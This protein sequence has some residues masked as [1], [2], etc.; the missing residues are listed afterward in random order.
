MRTVY[1]VP[2]CHWDREWYQPQELFRWRLVRMI[3]ELLDHM[4][5]CPDFRCFNLDG[6][7]I[8]VADY[9]ALRPENEGRLR[10]LVASGR[11]TIGPWWVQPDEF[12]P[13]AE[14]HIRN[15]QRGVRYAERLS[16]CARVGHCADQFG[17][18]AQL[19]QIMRQFGLT[20]ACLWRGVPDSI[21][22]WSFW[23]ESP[24]GS[25]LPVLYLRNSYS[26]GWRL[27]EDVDG[28]LARAGREERDRRDN[29]PVLLMNGTDHSRMEKHV[30]AALAQA[31]GRG[32]DF[33]L[34]TL[35]EYEAAMVEAGFDATVHRGEL[36]SPDRSNILA[37]VL[38]ARLNLK[39][40]DFAVSSLL[41][42]CAEPLELLAFL[43]GGSDRR[44]ALRRAWDLLLENAPHDS[45]CGCS[46]DQVHREMLPRYDRA[47]Q[48]AGQVA[49]EAVAEMAPRF[50]LPPEG[51]LL[52]F[53]PIA[54]APVPVACHVPARWSATQVQLPSGDRVPCAL[55]PAAEDETL[56]DEDLSPAEILARVEF[57]REGL[58]DGRRVQAIR[59]QLR[60]RR[61][62]VD[63]VVGDG[64]ASF[65]DGPAREA[66]R[67]VVCDGLADAARLRVILEGTRT[68]RLSLPAADSVGLVLVRPDSGEVETVRSDIAADKDRIG[69][70]FFEV[71]FRR[72]RLQVHDWQNGI[73]VENANVFVDE[74]DRG[75]EYNADILPDAVLEP[76]SA[77]LL[78][79]SGDG[80]SATLRYLT[81]LDVPQ[82]LRRDRKARRRRRDLLPIVT[83]V[84]LW[85]GVPRVD[86]RVVVENT[87][88]DHRLR[89]LFPLPF[90]AASVW[91]ENQ[92]HVAERSI[93]PPPWNGVS[94][95]QPPVTFPQKTFAACEAEEIGLAVLNRGLPEG[96]VVR[97]TGGRQALALTLL[98]CVGW[99][100][101]TDL[102]SRRGGAGPAMA[103]PEAQ[104]PGPH[105]FDYALTT[106]R[107]GWQAAGVLP[108]A[109]AF[110]H[111]SLAFPA[112]SAGG[113]EVALPLVRVTPPTAMTSAL[114]RSDVDGA[115]LIRVWNASEEATEAIVQVLAAGE[116]AGLVDLLDRHAGNVD[117]ATTE[118]WRFPLRPWEIAT[119][120]FGRR[121]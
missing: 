103:T 38:S 58:Y 118:G 59:W 84:T 111:P 116:G 75:D 115:P 60:H 31:A 61:L 89:V 51:G 92:F 47:E 71:R 82:G 110:A 101:R 98:R 109:H 5:R 26:N 4:E 17:H 70:R 88:Q 19:P 91:T 65:D 106:Y 11:V 81:L 9:L 120:R 46:V 32:Y 23:W 86:F 10:A 74:G 83:E 77:E 44:A 1:V 121:G 99:L 49:R 20:S 15:L 57:V 55:G 80:V 24:D 72:G 102:T 79:V 27:P 48:L 39:Q 25:R 63:I 45:I 18:V 107:G 13:S 90:A 30:P 42:R 14:S 112:S 16:D 73:D 12:L 50:A 87:V 35:A 8:V 34:A 78:E 28:L 76:A 100:S 53:R 33:C 97:D 66:L 119:V 93:T 6:Q 43:H 64:I 95:E 3:D 2:H 96:E 85:S 54:G 67:A 41:E 37:G 52:I 56:S 40:R 36:R 105:I 22:G 29:E 108:L 117:D 114:H 69:N 104:L 62:G 21:P 94:M 7:S 113:D 68:L